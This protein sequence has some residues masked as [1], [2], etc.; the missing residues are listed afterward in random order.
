MEDVWVT[1]SQGA[2]PRWLEDADVRRGIRAMLKHDR[3]QEELTRLQREALNISRF[4]GTQLAA[5]ESALKDPA[6]E[7]D[8]SLI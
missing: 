7:C 1:P 6:S 3:C 2:I 8:P 4:S 5:V